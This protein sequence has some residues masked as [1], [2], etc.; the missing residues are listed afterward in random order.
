AEND[1]FLKLRYYYQ[2][3]RSMH[4]SGHFADGNSIYD[5]YIANYKSKS[6]VKGWALAF[7]AGEERRI[8][9]KAKAAY[10]FSKVFIKYPERRLQAYTNYSYI[11]APLQNVVKL[12]INNNEKAFI[13]AIDG[14]NTPDIS[15]NALQKVYECQPSSPLIKTL[16]IREIN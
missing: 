14:F 10:L 7:K 9:N 1:K 5:R 8:G 6:H 12:A 11:K 2:A 3:Q 4:Y 15:L 16:L 13:Y